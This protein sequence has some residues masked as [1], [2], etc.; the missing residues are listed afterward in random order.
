M[1]N[2]DIDGL[3]SFFVY[4]ALKCNGPILQVNVN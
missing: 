2:I 1:G 3:L 4:H